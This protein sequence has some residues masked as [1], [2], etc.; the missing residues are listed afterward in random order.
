MKAIADGKTKEKDTKDF[1]ISC[2][3]KYATGK[4]LYPKQFPNATITPVQA[5]L[6]NIIIHRAKNTQP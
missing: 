1:I 5:T 2:L 4:T 6:L 3:K